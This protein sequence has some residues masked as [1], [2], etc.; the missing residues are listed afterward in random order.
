MLYELEAKAAIQLCSIPNRFALGTGKCCD[1]EFRR[2]APRQDKRNPARAHRHQ[3]KKQHKFIESISGI[4]FQAF[5]YDLR[6]R[7][8]ILRRIYLPQIH[9]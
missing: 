8:N 1:P 6:S 2:F 7:L 5:L 4:K 3:V 9:R